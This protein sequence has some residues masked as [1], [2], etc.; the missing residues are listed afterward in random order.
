MGKIVLILGALVVGALLLA[1][2]GFISTQFVT[3]STGADGKTSM[4]CYGDCAGV[5]TTGGSDLMQDVASL[6][7][8][9]Q[10]V[11]LHRAGQSFSALLARAHRMP[12]TPGATLLWRLGRLPTSNLAAEETLLA[13]RLAAVPLRTSGGAVCRRAA[14]RLVSRYAWALGR[15]RDELGGRRPTWAAVRR[16]DDAKRQSDRTYAREV[17]PCLE[18]ASGAERKALARAMGAS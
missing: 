5:H 8:A 16:F 12:H 4:R 14:V 7:A 10:S 17:L 13:G 3:S 1:K 2:A 9:G 11:S 6:G 15:F 18:S